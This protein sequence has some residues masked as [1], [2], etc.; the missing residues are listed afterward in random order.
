[1]FDLTVICCNCGNTIRLPLTKPA[2]RVLDQLLL[3][4]GGLPTNVL[5]PHCKRATAYSPDKFHRTFFEKPPQDRFPVEQVCACIQVRCGK[6]DCASLVSIRAGIGVSDNM[7]EDALW[8]L[9]E[10]LLSDVICEQGHLSSRRVPSGSF[11][12]LVDPG[13]ESLDWELLEDDE[14]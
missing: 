1:M 2:P 12:T 9:V 10:S 5:C 4:G 14:E 6:E 3:S 11:R 13:W 8:L 7:R